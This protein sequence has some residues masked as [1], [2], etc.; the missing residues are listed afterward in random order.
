MLSKMKN[1]IKQ[2]LDHGTRRPRPGG[3]PRLIKKPKF[4]DQVC[5]WR[6]IIRAKQERKERIEPAYKP[7]AG[8]NGF[9]TTCKDYVP[10][11]RQGESGRRCQ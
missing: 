2:I 3:L 9:Y 8:C 10:Y 6:I 11:R 7:C 4:M 5:H 1:P